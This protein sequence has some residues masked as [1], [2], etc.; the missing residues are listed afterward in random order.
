MEG[1]C[2]EWKEARSERGGG[3]SGSGGFRE[4]TLQK[5]WPES[6]ESPPFSSALGSG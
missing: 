4:L 1:T 3:G 5:P 6:R 2:A